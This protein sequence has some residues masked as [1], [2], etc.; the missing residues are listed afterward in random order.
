MNVCW[1]VRTVKVKKSI[2]P[3]SDYEGKG[4]DIH[5]SVM[6][7]FEDARVLTRRFVC[8]HKSVIYSLLTDAS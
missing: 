1:G 3:A 5:C 7:T 4:K 8:T 6:E 2:V